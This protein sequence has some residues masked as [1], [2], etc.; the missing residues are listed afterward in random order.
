MEWLLKCYT[1]VQYSPSR[2]FPEPIFIYISYRCRQDRKVCLIFMAVLASA[3]HHVV[4]LCL[5]TMYVFNDSEFASVEKEG[6]PVRVR[7]RT[8]ILGISLCTS[9]GRRSWEP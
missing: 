1:R 5:Q 9:F 7:E 2:G 3:Q 6:K 8:V 4:D